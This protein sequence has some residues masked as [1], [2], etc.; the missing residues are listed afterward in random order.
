MYLILK[1]LSEAELTDDITQCVA[2]GTY[3]YDYSS[4]LNLRADTILAGFRADESLMKALS[5]WMEKGSAGSDWDMESSFLE[6]TDG[7]TYGI[8]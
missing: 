5:D 1:A 6:A 8:Q 2:V 7:G 3:T 4:L